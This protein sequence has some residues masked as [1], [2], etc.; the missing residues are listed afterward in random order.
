M[1]M[2][3][4]RQKRGFTLVEIMISMSVI[5][6]VVVAATNLLVSIIRS[7]ASNVSTMIAYGLA[8]EGVEAVRNIRDSDWLL[9]GNFQ[10]VVGNRASMPWGDGLPSV[11]GQARNYTIDFNGMDGVL[12]SPNMTVRSY[13]LSQYAPWVLSLVPDSDDP[14]SSDVTKLFKK[15]FIGGEIRYTHS[16]G[17]GAAET[18]FHRY[19]EITP[20]QYAQSTDASE[21]VKKFRVVSVVAWQEFGRDR[22]VRLDTE[23]TDWKK[24]Q[25]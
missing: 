2:L 6:V 8:Q 14:K 22:Q 7:N 17:N 20:E 9:G 5:V 12:S 11:V 15:E 1:N 19:V 24:G 16:G 21:P 25:L 23:L 4:K 10:G 13:E 18:P 3:E